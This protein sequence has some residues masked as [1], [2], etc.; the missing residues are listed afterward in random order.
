MLHLITPAYRFNNLSKIWESIAPYPDVMWHIGKS[1]FREDITNLPEDDGR[2]KI[3]NADIPDR[4]GQQKRMIA[5]SGVTEGYFC[6]LDDDT[7]LHPGMYKAYKDA[8]RIGYEGM[9][10]GRQI[11]KD[12]KMRLR[13]IGK[14]VYCQI[15]AGNVLCHHSLLKGYEWHVPQGDDA[16][17]KHGGIDYVFWSGLYKQSK[18]SQPYANVISVYNQLAK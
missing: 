14:P 2:I 15:D 5:L 16:A 7:L 11:N 4:K 1:K 12:G 6:L 17:F 10:I 8:E 9:F 18:K 13:E 3:Y